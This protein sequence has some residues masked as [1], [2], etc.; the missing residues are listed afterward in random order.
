A[1]AV[2]A[3]RAPVF[4]GLRSPRAAVSKTLGDLWRLASGAHALALADQAGVGGASFL[5]TLMIGRWDSPSELGTC[6]IRYS[7]LVSSLAVQES[8]IS[9]PYSIQRYRPSGTPAEHAGGSLALS[10]MMAA[11]GVIVLTVTALA[12]SMWGAGPAL[13]AMTW[14]LAGVMPFVLMREF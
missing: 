7:I 6:A 10:A 13:V 12:L 5:T 14:A 9:L 4:P 2:L 3:R 1:G 8:L 11:T